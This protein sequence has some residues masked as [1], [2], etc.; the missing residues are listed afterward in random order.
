MS[1]WFCVRELAD[2]VWEISEPGHVAFWL[3]GGDERAALID[4]GCGFAA[5]RPVVE[6]LTD[7]PVL[8]VNSHNHLDHIG[9]NAEWEEIAIH[10]LGAAGLEQPFP[11]AMFAAYLDHAADMVHAYS[12]YREL[13]RRFFHLLSDR[14]DVRALPAAAVPGRWQ[15]APSRATQTI[16]E[17]D[18][19]E[20]GGRFLRVLHTPGHSPDCLCFE[21]ASERLLIGTDTVNTGPVYAH[22]PDSDPRL[23]RDSLARLAT[24]SER[25]DRVLCA[26]FLRTEVAPAYLG[27]QVRALDELLAGQVALEPAVDCVGTPALEARFDGYS[28]LVDSG[29]GAAEV[30]RQPLA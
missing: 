18:V 25:W 1:E 4:S 28:F 17:G 20:L 22:L 14:H 9:G 3:V 26:H 6:G 5:L 21:L 30:P 27:D 16:D 23:L 12:S 11:P 10:P 24:E 7:R 15:I 2:R 19:I 29:W 13:D 8:V